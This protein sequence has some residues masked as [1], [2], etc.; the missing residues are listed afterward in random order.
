MSALQALVSAVLVLLTVIAAFLGRGLPRYVAK[1]APMWRVL[2]WSGAVI[3]A[4][5]IIAISLAA[6]GPFGLFFGI[7]VA[8][9]AAEYALFLSAKE[10]WARGLVR[11]LQTRTID[12]HPETEAKFK[13][14]RIGRIILRLRN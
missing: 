4:V 10:V 5:P 3:F 11:R 12:R 9:L 7:P 2:G 14:S 1:S 8:I 6:A 13:R